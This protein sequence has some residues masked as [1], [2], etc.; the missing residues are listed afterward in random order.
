MKRRCVVVP[1]TVPDKVKCNYWI[2]H[3]LFVSEASREKNIGFFF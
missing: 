2:L 3:G 1:A